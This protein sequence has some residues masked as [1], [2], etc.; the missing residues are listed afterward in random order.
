MCAA[1]RIEVFD[2]TLRDGSQGEGV[3]FS[4]VDKLEIARR[5]DEVGFDFIEGG[6][7]GSNPKDAQFFEEARTQVF[8]RARLAAF[9]ATRRAKL[10]AAD[11]PSIR[12]LAEAGT[13]TVVLFGKA[14]DLH[15]RDALRVEKRDNLLM[16]EESVAYL[17]ACGKDVIF[18]AE[19]FFDGF[20]SDSGYALEC[21]RA[22]ARAGASRHVLCETNGGALPRD[23]AAA[24][25]RVRATL[26]GVTLGI[27]THNDSGL[28]V[29][30]AIAAVDA[31]C[32]QVHGTVNGLGERCGNADLCVLIPTLQLK[33]GYRV[34][35]DDKLAHLTDLSRYVYEMA[36]LP[37]RDYQ[38]YVGRSAFAHKGGVH[39]S[40]VQRNPVTYE[41]VEPRRVGNER[42]FLL[43]ELSGRATVCE[44][45]S[46]S[47]GDA[48][49]M[50]TILQRV[51]DLEHAGYQ[52]E[53]AEASFEIL[54]RKII[55][56]HRPYFELEGFR[57]ISELTDEDVHLTEATIKL[58]VGDAREHTAAEGNGPVNALDSALRKALIRSYP[59]LAQLHLTNYKVRIV[60]PLASTAARVL[61]LIESR[62]DRDRWATVGVSE[63]IIEA[64][65]IALVDSVEYK[66]VR[67]GMAP[68]LGAGASRDGSL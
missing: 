64:S 15:V 12:Q 9:G 1:E 8:S 10:A 26:P 11:D 67:D 19:H 47:S 53:A 7:P 61:V 21:L 27:H 68:P 36:M 43:S 65:W 29:A 55:G 24:V 48:E 44:K 51:Q 50:Q 58:R 31:G 22:A 16:I 17:V 13:P 60:N 14:W 56:T 5:L 59:S 30:N 39:V 25:E 45:L 6:W 2:T 38:P 34:L 41:H 52:F 28:A 40:A 46:G 23:V 57:V 54:S 35:D 33:M 63:N 20:R 62:D 49:K 18:D 66:L 32:R 4:V 3:S 42:R 37:P